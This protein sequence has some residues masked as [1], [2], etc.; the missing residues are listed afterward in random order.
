MQTPTDRKTRKRNSSKVNLTISIIFHSV[1]VSFVLFYAA[2]EGMLGAA[3]KKITVTMEP[4]EKPPEKPKPPPPP[5]ETKSLEEKK[6]EAETKPVEAPKTEEAKTPPA[7]AP[8]AVVVGELPPPAAIPADFA[9]TEPG[10]TVVQTGGDPK[11]V[12]NNLVQYTLRSIWTYPRQ[13]KDS[14]IF[15][16]VEVAVDPQGGMTVRD[17]KRKSGNK[18]WDD[19]VEKVFQQVHSI[20]RPP[21]AGFPADV[22]VRFDL[23][24]RE[25][26]SLQ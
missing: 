22:L 3:L 14:G 23:V 15:S 24:P 21:P 5:P 12:Y 9:F 6:P 7:E 17:W 11:E 25:T 13:M 16:E 26:S 1:L 18:E 4:K 8:P 2:H 20:R 10:A 19:S